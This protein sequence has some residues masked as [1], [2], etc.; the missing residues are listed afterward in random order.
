MKYDLP[1]SHKVIGM[2]LHPQSVEGV[3]EVWIGEVK[4][5]PIAKSFIRK[6]EKTAWY[7]SFPTTEKLEA[8]ASEWLTKQR[9]CHIQRESMKVTRKAEATSF[10]TSLVAGDMVYSSWG[11]DQTN[12]D[13]WQVIEVSESGKSVTMREVSQKYV[14]TGFMSGNVVPVA[15]DFTGEPSR[16]IVKPGDRVCIGKSYTSAN[17]WDGSPKYTSHYA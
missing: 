6:S 14:E 9:Q 4:G 17:K 5:K 11:Y 16:H 8:Y 10:R 3:A 7:Y 1:K 2:T 15:D 12:V 13:F